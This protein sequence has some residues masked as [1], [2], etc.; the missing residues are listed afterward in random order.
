MFANYYVNQ[1]NKLLTICIQ[2]SFDVMDTIYN[3]YRTEKRDKNG[4]F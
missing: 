3:E 4:Y 2:I 1:M